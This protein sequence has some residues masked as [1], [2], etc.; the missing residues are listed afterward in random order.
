M[1]ASSTKK[2]HRQLKLKLRLFEVVFYTLKTM[3]NP[4]YSL[5][6][7]PSNEPNWKV[8][9]LEHLADAAHVAYQVKEQ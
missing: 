5:P 4:F 6:S 1:S 7:G 9:S 8:M 3:S 2:Q